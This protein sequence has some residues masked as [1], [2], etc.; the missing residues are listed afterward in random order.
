MRKIRLTKE[1]NFEMAHALWNYDGPCSNIHGHSYVLAVTLIGEPVQDKDN[2][3]NGM[4]VDFGDIKKWVKNR[5]VD[6]F[7]HSL[8]ISNDA[9]VAEINTSRQMFNRLKIVDFQPTCEN[10]LFYIAEVIREQLPENIQLHSLKLQ[11]TAT[12]W[13]EWY[14]EDNL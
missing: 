9:D 4:V 6:D 13:A 2:P 10:L 7:D 8:L 5:I 11:E 1:F 14:A 3:K 12:S